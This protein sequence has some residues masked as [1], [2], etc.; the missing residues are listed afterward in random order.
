V[1]TTVSACAPRELAAREVYDAECALHAAR[2]A[3]VDAWTRAA[4]RPTA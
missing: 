1:M 2:Q 4:S 3:G